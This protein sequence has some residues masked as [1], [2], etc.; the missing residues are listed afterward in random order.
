M[1]VELKSLKI[2]LKIKARWINFKELKNLDLKK[3]QVIINCTSLG[4]GSRVK[5]MPIQKQK[6]KN[7]KKIH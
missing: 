3:F 5:K 1:L 7:I 6:I 2:L 4:F